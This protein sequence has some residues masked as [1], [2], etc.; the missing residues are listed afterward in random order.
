MVNTHF[1]LMI[2]ICP[3]S[4]PVIAT[5]NEYNLFSLQL[6]TR[7]FVSSVHESEEFAPIIMTIIVS[8]VLERLLGQVMAVTWASV[9]YRRC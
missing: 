4:A 7:E 8:F 9:A 1:D 3:I 2:N 6:Y 5:I